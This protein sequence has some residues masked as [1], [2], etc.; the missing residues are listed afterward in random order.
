[1]ND[2][3]E[4]TDLWKFKCKFCRESTSTRENMFDVHND[5]LKHLSSCPDNPSNK[6]CK[7]CNF[8]TTNS[9]MVQ[10][11]ICCNPENRT[12]FLCFDNGGKLYVNLYGTCPL[13]TWRNNESKP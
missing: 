5:A 2:G 10:R 13:W 3:I 4:L 8:C 9:T 1:M 7:T 11:G 6:M 12:N